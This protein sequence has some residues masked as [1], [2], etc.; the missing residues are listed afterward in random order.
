MS[1]DMSLSLYLHIPF[2]STKCSY[3]A[4]NTYTDLEGLI[5]TFVGSLADEV[6]LLAKNA[7][8]TQ[9]DTIYFGGGTPSLLRPEQ[10]EQLLQTIVNNWHVST[11]AE[12]T[13][14]ANPNDLSESYLRDLRKLG[15][16]RISIGM[17][18]AIPSE[19]QLF[20]RRHD[21]QMVIDAVK[22]A[23]IAG[24]DNLSLDLIYGIPHQTL[25][26][27]QHSLQ[28]ALDLQ[29]EH[30]SLYALGLEGGTP[31]KDEVDAGRLPVPDDDL[32]A[33]MYD[34]ATEML[35]SAGFE[36]Y[37]ISNWAKPGCES[38][39]NLQY[40]LNLPYAGLGP[41]AHGYAGGYRYSVVLSP[42]K[43]IQLMQNPAAEY[44]FPRTP[45]TARI[46]PVDR[47]TEI[48][49]TLMMG[50]RL[51]KRGINRAEFKRRFDTDVIEL[52]AE[53]L[54]KFERH[55]I[56]TIDDDTV[57]LTKAG[58]FLSNAVIRELV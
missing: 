53:T 37:E 9:V 44:E 49:E 28:A 54:A 51:T 19:L 38:R 46:V 45:A 22:A 43:Y 10:F 21:S 55:G 14:E 4:F 17:Q 2:C 16:N 47:Q 27:W 25:E 3:C 31:L 23:R 50:L 48:A 13:F 7:P 12:I 24:F 5:D 15:L 33:D 52:H 29:I 20:N 42:Q 58:R 26:N 8:T 11:D 36:Q 57:R 40:W 6:R 41:G 30:I 34:V 56:V 18:T 1:S 32:S 35:E 39:H